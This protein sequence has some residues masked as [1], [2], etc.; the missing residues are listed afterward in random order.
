MEKQ[1]RLIDQI[2][3]TQLKDLPHTIL[4]RGQEGGDHQVIVDEL[5]QTFSFSVLDMTENISLE[6]IN[7]LI[8]SP[9]TRLCTVRMDEVTEKEQNVLLKFLE[10]PSSNIWII[11][12]VTD[13]N[14]GRVLNTIQNRCV[15]WELERYSLSDIKKCCDDPIICRY[16][17]TPAQV[18]QLKALPLA[19]ME[20]F[21]AKVTQSIHKAYFGNCLVITGKLAFKKEDSGYP[22]KLFMEMIR[23]SYKD[24]YINEL[25]NS[26]LE[27]YNIMREALSDLAEFPLINKEWFWNR[28]M[29]KLRRAMKT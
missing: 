17:K 21:A 23:D 8:S 24:R 10:E 16:A 22:V 28:L 1:Q 5:I 12:L 3:N 27:C 25:D 13:E 7:D 14:S 2:K 9:A 11:L 18:T 4:L 15:V 26:F 20:S 19:E 6:T 29:I